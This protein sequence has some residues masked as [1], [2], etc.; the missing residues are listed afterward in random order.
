MVHQADLAHKP[1]SA[2]LGSVT[3]N[4]KTMVVIRKQR[5]QAHKAPGGK[6]GTQ[7]SFTDIHDSD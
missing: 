6:P 4:T 1:G 3:R 2:T 7:K 5:D